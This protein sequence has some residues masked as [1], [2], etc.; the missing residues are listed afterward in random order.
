MGMRSFD[1]DISQGWLQVGGQ[2]KLVMGFEVVAQDV[3]GHGDLVEVN[4]GMPGAIVYQPLL[5]LLQ[6]SHIFC[7]PERR[8]FGFNKPDRQARFTAVTQDAGIPVRGGKAV[9]KN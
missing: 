7:R 1:P 8:W 2:T 5:V 9:G 3:S 6:Q 4:A